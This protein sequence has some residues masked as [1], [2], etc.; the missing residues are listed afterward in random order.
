VF[1]CHAVAVT[2]ANKKERARLETVPGALRTTETG[3]V[4]EDVRQSRTI[5]EYCVQTR[6]GTWY[7][8][9]AEQFR[10]AELGHALEV[11]E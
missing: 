9:S 1:V 11:C 3:R 7:R 8:V 5:R 10:S 6:E 2:V 4:E